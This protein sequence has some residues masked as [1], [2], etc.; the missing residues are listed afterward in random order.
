MEPGAPPA[1]A[2]IGQDAAID[3]DAD[4]TDPVDRWAGT[5][6]VAAE[7][8]LLLDAAGQVQALSVAAA[9]LLGT[10]SAAAQ[11]RPV[12]SVLMLVDFSRRAMPAGD[13]VIALPALRSVVHR[14]LARG[15]IRVQLGG[16]AAGPGMGAE[17]PG[18]APGAATYDMVSVPVAG[19]G[20]LAFLL[21]L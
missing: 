20:A 4:P 2:R 21:P 17:N 19:G 9:E 18:F 6:R 13:P 3:L 16:S 12:E 10:T 8:C 5:V 1:T 11:G 15:L 7:P 14:V